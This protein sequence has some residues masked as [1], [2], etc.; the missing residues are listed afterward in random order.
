MPR[1]RDAGFALILAL[2]TLLVLTMMALALSLAS[3]TEI[4]ASANQRWA[5]QAL[6][7]AEAG[8]EAGRAV[9]RDVSWGS[10]LPPARVVPWMPGTPGA[11]PPAPASRAKRNYENGTCDTQ[12]NGVGYGVVLDTGGPEPFE[13]VSGFFGQPVNGTVTLW[14]RRRL[15]QNADGSIADDPSDDD[16]ILTSEGGAPFASV[17]DAGRAA[18][19]QAIR[20]FEAEVHRQPAAGGGWRVDS[21]RERRGALTCR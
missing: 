6:Y 2:L 4:Q 16:L 3:S 15:V 5:Q 8:I 17:Q 18:S 13:E 12:G 14:V 21:V 9:L 10:V 1:R 11:P 7:N 20:F 19:L